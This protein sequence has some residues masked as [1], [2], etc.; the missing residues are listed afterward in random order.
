MSDADQQDEARVVGIHLPT[1]HVYAR[2]IP[3]AVTTWWMTAGIM[4]ESAAMYTRLLYEVEQK[5]PYAK[6]HKRE[7]FSHRAHSVSAIVLGAT[8]VEAYANE[9][10][11]SPSGPLPDELRKVVRREWESGVP[12]QDRRPLAKWHALKKLDHALQLAAKPRLDLNGEAAKETWVAFGLR[13]AF[14]HLKPRRS[15]FGDPQLDSHMELE[16]QLLERAFIRDAYYPEDELAFPAKCFSHA[17]AE[18][19]VHS[20]LA[21]LDDYADKMGTHRL[22]DSH[23]CVTR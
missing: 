8:A 12:D 23:H 1:I 22:R 15:P 21:L 7:R 19:A 17:C 20:H 3:L 16:K 13:N 6:T 9:Q 10:L 5:A 4:M 2:A 18:W 11:L 14:A